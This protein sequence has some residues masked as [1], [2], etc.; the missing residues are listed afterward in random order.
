M[1]DGYNTQILWVDLTEMRTEIREPGEEVIR[2][3]IGGAGLDCIST[4]GVLAFAI[5]C[6]KKG[7]LSKNDAGGIDLTWGNHRAMVE[8]VKKSGRERV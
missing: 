8:M 5:E 7:L 2:K 3:Y 1:A 4:G 6:Y